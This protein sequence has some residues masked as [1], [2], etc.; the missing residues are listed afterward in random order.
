MNVT[1]KLTKLAKKIGFGLK[2]HGP[3]IAVIGGCVGVGASMV[4][5]AVGTHKADKAVAEAND[6]IVKKEAETGKPKEEIDKKE[7]RPIYISTTGRVI[8]AY[9]PAAIV[10][11]A[12]IAAIL[13]SHKE[14]SARVG[15]LAAIAASLKASMDNPNPVKTEIV[16]ETDNG[17]D[18]LS[19]TIDSEDS[20]KNPYQVVF[21]AKTSRLWEV[22]PEL[23]YCSLRRIEWWANDKLKADGYLFLSAVLE[24]LGFEAKDFPE[25]FKMA[26]VV[27]W[28]VKGDGDGYVS[29][30]L[31]DRP[32]DCVIQ[33]LSDNEQGFILNF[34]VDGYIL[35]KAFAA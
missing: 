31:E 23:N 33:I 29:F 14:M 9:A 7:L 24:E 1:R 32:T 26:Q 6:A 34:N 4:L 3:T 22:D 13:W 16:G 18:I 25:L 21:S 2:K 28:V 11:V 8:K 15:S 10:C 20:V 17:E 35:D 12:S 5:T 30:G 19:K 27:G